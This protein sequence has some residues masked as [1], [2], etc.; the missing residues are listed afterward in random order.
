MNANRRPLASLLVT[1]IASFAM[2]TPA[3]AQAPQTRADVVAE[4][5]A[6]IHNGDVMAPGGSG[7][8]MDEL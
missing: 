2:H 7:M 1:A 6:A 4:L 3:C 8:K 5:H